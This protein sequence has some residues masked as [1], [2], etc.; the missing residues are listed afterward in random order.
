MMQIIRS[1]S[2]SGAT[3]YLGCRVTQ[4]SKYSYVSL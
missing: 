1:F 3:V 4:F 2:K